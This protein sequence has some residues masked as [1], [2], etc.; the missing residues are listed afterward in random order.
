MQFKHI[1]KHE[2]RPK[3]EEYARPRI[4]EYSINTEIAELYA[5]QIH[6]QTSPKLK[7]NAAFIR[8][9]IGL[10]SSSVQIVEFYAF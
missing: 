8:T 7:K 3:I 2:R 5:F 1:L 4:V 9:E 6:S 10:N